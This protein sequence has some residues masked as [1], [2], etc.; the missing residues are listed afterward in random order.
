MKLIR[1][2]SFF[3]FAISCITHAHENKY[4]FVGQNESVGDAKTVFILEL[5]GDDFENY[6]YTNERGE[7]YLKADKVFA[8]SKEA[9]HQSVNVENMSNLSTTELSALLASDTE[10]VKCSN[11]RCGHIYWATRSDRHC[12]RCG[13]YN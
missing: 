12:P 10:R 8:I 2:L 4:I 9:L 5:L 1:V 6:V 7:V 13:T 3:L 11:P